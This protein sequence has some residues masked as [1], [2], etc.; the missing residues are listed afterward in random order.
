M[1]K[2]VLHFIHFFDIFITICFIFFFSEI[3]ATEISQLE[4]LNVSPGVCCL[5]WYCSI[6]C[7][8]HE[9]K[10]WHKS[11]GPQRNQNGKENTM[12]WPL[13]RILEC[14]NK[15]RI[16]TNY[17]G[18]LAHFSN[19]MTKCLVCVCNRFQNGMHE[20]VNS[21]RTTTNTP[22]YHLKGKKIRLILLKRLKIRRNEMTQSESDT[23]DTFNYTT[24][25]WC[26]LFVID[27]Q[28]FQCY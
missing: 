8:P 2:D 26:N 7:K 19:Y 25:F 28:S 20:K 14:S 6:A 4:S 27:M 24:F 23:H 9:E 5:I 13:P 10:K 12:E 15:D 1:R 16:Q 3:A 21:K 17:A 18:I 11:S 22:Y